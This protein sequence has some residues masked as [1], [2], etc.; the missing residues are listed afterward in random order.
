M[1]TDLHLSEPSMKLNSPL[2]LQSHLSSQSYGLESN[3]FTEITPTMSSDVLRKFLALR[4]MNNNQVFK[5]AQ[6]NLG[7]YFNNNSPPQQQQTSPPHLP[8]L[9]NHSHSVNNLNSLILPQAQTQPQQT[10][11]QYLLIP[12]SNISIA[13]TSPNNSQ[14]PQIIILHSTGGTAPQLISQMNQQAHSLQLNQLLN[15]QQNNIALN[16]APNLGGYSIIRQTASEV[17]QNNIGNYYNSLAQNN[18]NH[19]LQSVHLVN[20]PNKLNTTIQ[21]LLNLQDMAHQNHHGGHLLQNNNHLFLS[22]GGQ[23]YFSSR[24]SHFTG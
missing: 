11:N 2:E 23:N 14:Q 21:Q 15:S 5:P 10:Q 18:Y 4:E 3:P 8:L 9:L 22:G 7:N 16:S 20:D 24:N 13:Q 1:E 17:H 6:L 12:T 19:G